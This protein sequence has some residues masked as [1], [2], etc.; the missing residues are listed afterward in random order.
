MRVTTVCARVL[1]ALS[2]IALSTTASANTETE[3]ELVERMAVFGEDFLLGAIDAPV[4]ASP[5]RWAGRLSGDYVY[6]FV[7]GSDGGATTQVERHM[8]DPDRPEVAWERHIGDRMVETFVD[9]VLSV[10]PLKAEDDRFL[11]FARDVGLVAEIEGIRASA[12]FRTQE[13]SAKVLVTYPA[14]AP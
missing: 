5:A 7:M 6:Q 14:E 8:P 4:I 1:I 10:G 3:A 9:F 2:T 12:L 13:D 11:F